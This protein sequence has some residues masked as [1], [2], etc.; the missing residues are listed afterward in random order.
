MIK[1]ILVCILSIVIILSMVACK[2]EEVPEAENFYIVEHTEPALTYDIKT[3]MVDDWRNDL[4]NGDRE[5]FTTIL[6]YSED[7]SYEVVEDDIEFLNSNSEYVKVLDAFP[8]AEISIINSKMEA[9]GTNAYIKIKTNTIIDTKKLYVRVD[10]EIV[11]SGE[12]K[13][14]LTSISP[15]TTPNQTAIINQ[16]NDTSGMLRLTND[17]SSLYYYDFS[18]NEVFTENDKHVVKIYLEQYKEDGL[19][20]FASDCIGADMFCF[21]EVERDE[22]KHVWLDESISLSTHVDGDYVV[23]EFTTLDGSNIEEKIDMI[24][25]YLTCG[26]GKVVNFALK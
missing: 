1:K 4:E 3:Y 7:Y 13:A 18:K 20:V 24:P 23:V 14:I 9:D 19:D 5:Y 26:N 11:G 6:T 12:N 8:G 2:S 17:L 16:L 25:S 15:S 10:G 21:V 22:M